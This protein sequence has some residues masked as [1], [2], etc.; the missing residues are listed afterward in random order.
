MCKEANAAHAN[1]ARGYFW[2]ILFMLATPATIFT[3]MGSYFYWLVRKANADRAVGST[4][5]SR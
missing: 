5:D 2:S 3:G 4:D 1:I